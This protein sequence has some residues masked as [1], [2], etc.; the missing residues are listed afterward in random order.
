MLLF[1]VPGQVLVS[2]WTLEEIARENITDT[3]M[4]DSKSKFSSG[5][6]IREVER[7]MCYILL[8]QRPAV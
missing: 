1:H 5:E 6:G 8:F 7:A 2:V 3:R 4:K